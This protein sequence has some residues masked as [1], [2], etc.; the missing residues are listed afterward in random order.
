MGRKHRDVIAIERD[1]DQQVQVTISQ[2]TEGGGAIPGGFSQLFNVVISTLSYAQLPEAS[3]LIYPALV[4]MA[5]HRRQFVI[6]NRGYSE[7]ARYAGVSRSTAQ[8]G[9]ARL[10]GCGLVRL[11]RPAR[12]DGRGGLTAN[13]YQ[14]L[15]PIEG[16]EPPPTYTDSRERGMPRNNIGVSR[17]TAQ[18]STV[19]RHSSVPRIGR[20]IQ[21]EELEHNNKARQAL[22]DAGIAEPVLTK[23]VESKPEEELLLR[24]RD[25]KTRKKLGAK[26]GVA[27]LIA[28]IRETYDL[29]EQTQCDIDNERKGSLAT[30]H[31]LKQFDQE[32]L[33]EEEQRKLDEQANRML[34][35]MSEEECEHWRKIVMS[36][37]PSL[38]RGLEKTDPK[39]EGRLRRLILGKLVHLIAPEKRQSAGSR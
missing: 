35:E 24:L 26:L 38:T 4:W 10:I 6:E 28:S 31:R 37:L 8:K 32:R 25:W 39:K 34:D 23:L 22:A 12:P 27:W 16:L 9:L 13:I 15:V 17:E 5:D 33:A 2:P 20:N 1:G 14:L 11:V 30:A 29:H 36:E 3:K 21:E 19:N 18:R 7:I